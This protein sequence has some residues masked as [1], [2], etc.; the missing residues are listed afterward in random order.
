MNRSPIALACNQSTATA[1]NPHVLN[2]ESSSHHEF[3]FNMK[4][5]LYWVKIWN[6]LSRF[7]N[8]NGSPIAQ[9]CSQSTATADHHHF[10]WEKSRTRYVFRFKIKLMKH[11]IKLCNRLLR[12]YK[13]NV[14]P[15]RVT[16]SRPT[17]TAIYPHVLH[18]KS[19]SHHEFRFKMKLKLYWVH[20]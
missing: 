7:I 8:W 16:C 6:R 3:R 4:L 17:A 13:W 15:T 9:A 12:S 20:K 5:K 1:D 11:L 18:E 10:L 2:E 14:S 19:S